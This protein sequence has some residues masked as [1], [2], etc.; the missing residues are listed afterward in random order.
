MTSVLRIMT[1]LLL[2]L[3]CACGKKGP[4]IPPDGK[5]PPPI[6]TLRVDQQG[7]NFRISW[8]APEQ[9][10]GYPPLAGYRVYRR[11]VRSPSSECP[12]C[13]A[14]DILIKTVDPEYLQDVIRLGA[15]LVVV[16]SDVKTGTTYQ[17]QVTALEKS[18][19]ENRDSVRVKRRKVLPPPAPKVRLEEVPAGIMLAW[20][21]VTTEA[22]TLSGYTVYRLR[23]AERYAF[24]PANPV[25]LKEPGYEDLRMEPDTI[26]R[27]QVRAVA[28]VDGETVESA[29]SPLVEGK[30]ILP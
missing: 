11:E 21:P 4:L 7:E 9:G 1:F 29:P 12:E 18:G 30:F 26:Y 3:C 8:L 28:L 19:A 27:Y 6:T 22:G 25:P 13:G 5:A 20:E 17:Y 16:D 15:I 14:T 24:L 23:P 10:P 2:V